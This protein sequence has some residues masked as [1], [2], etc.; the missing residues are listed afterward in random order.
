[1]SASG[2]FFAVKPMEE[3][4]AIQGIKGSFHYQVAQECFGRDILVDECRTFKGVIDS[5]LSGSST[6]AVMA[7]EN[8]T[9]GSILPNFALIDENNI[10]ITGEHYIPIHM[11]L[12]AVPGQK[13]E[14][15]TEVYSHPIA[16]LQCKNFFE[17]FPEMKLIET[18]D[19]AEAARKISEKRSL[20]MA[21]IAGTVAADLYGLEI[22]SSGIHSMKNNAT[23]FLILN[24][25][26]NGAAPDKVNKASLKFELD[27]HHGSLASVLNILND[28]NLN[29]SKIQSLPIV[30]TPWK[31]SFFVD[32]TFNKYE[33]YQKAMGIVKVLTEELKILGEYKNNRK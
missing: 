1:M 4:I 27:D 12:M 24:V 33:E 26:K 22:L 29:L 20:G 10:R 15:I 5:L 3:K 19:T 11:D 6:S 17:D 25:G 23:R 32:V 8:S 13:L 30:E 21:A 18:S 16:L 7:I 31:Y 14:D 2:F 28:C 9:A